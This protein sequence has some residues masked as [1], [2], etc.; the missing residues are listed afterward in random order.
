LI[1]LRKYN[2]I[3]LIT[4]CLNDPQNKLSTYNDPSLILWLKNKEKFDEKIYKLFDEKSDFYKELK[5]IVEDNKDYNNQ[6]NTISSEEY[7]ERYKLN[8]LGYSLKKPERSYSI[9]V[10]EKVLT[11]GSGSNF[12]DSAL[13]KGESNR[14]PSMILEMQQ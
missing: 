12:G 4:S 10:Y 3:R 1:N 9:F 5:S 7:I 2:E 6:N 14:Y 13:V 8:K 11:L